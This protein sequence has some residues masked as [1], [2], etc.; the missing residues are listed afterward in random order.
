MGFALFSMAAVVALM[1]AAMGSA[2]SQ[3]KA[4]AAAFDALWR[5]PE[6]SGTVFTFLLLSLAF[7]EALTLFVFAIIY[8]LMLRVP[9]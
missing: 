8:I 4:A 7:M 5:Q 1:G 6:I 3:A 9:V 2:L